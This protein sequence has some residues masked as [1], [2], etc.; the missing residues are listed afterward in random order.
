LSFFA[1]SV[2]PTRAREN[3]ATADA[4]NDVSVAMMAA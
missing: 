2:E 4:P 1:S 3:F